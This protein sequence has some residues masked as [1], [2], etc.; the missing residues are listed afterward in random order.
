MSIII[1]YWVLS[2]EDSAKYIEVIDKH[3]EAIKKAGSMLKAATGCDEIN[4]T[5]DG[6]IV[7]SYKTKQDKPFLYKKPSF[8]EHGMYHYYVKINTVQ[9][10]VLVAATKLLRSYKCIKE[11]LKEVYP[12]TQFRIASLDTGS[13]ITLHKTTFG[14]LKGQ[15]IMAYPVDSTKPDY[16]NVPEGFTEI[17]NTQYV[18]LCKDVE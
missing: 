18:Q 5:T 11:V 6:R 12:D 10:E 1:T 9:H 17:T 3:N 14:F 2:K 16:N 8:N 15:V 7:L 4:F 13:N